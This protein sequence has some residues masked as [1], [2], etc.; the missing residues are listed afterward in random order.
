MPNIINPANLSPGTTGQVY[1]SAGVS[2][3]PS[4][5]NPSPLVYFSAYNSAPI[6]NVTGD[7]TTYNVIF[8]TALSN[9][10]GGYNT[11]TG[12]FTSPIASKYFI[13]YSLPQL[14]VDLT[15]QT[16]ATSFAAKSGGDPNFTTY[17]INP[18]NVAETLDNLWVML[19][20]C[21]LSLALNET[22]QVS[23]QVVGGAKNVSIDSYGTFFGWSI[24]T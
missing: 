4:I 24:G 18:A 6:S 23:T 10:G 1:T 2:T 5:A 19:N 17:Y 8:N 21:I 13:G 15:G 9:V 22:I 20:Y 7:S 12:I 3:H 14:S 11:S 16:Y